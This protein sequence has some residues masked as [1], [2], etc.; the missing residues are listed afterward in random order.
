MRLSVTRLAREYPED[1]EQMLEDNMRLASAC[2]AR[3]VDLATALI[4]SMTRQGRDM[5]MAE[6]RRLGAH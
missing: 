1:V 5:V 2:E 6:A 4:R 3:D